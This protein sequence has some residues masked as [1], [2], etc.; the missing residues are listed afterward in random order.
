MGFF[1]NTVVKAREVLDVA[2]KRTA[3]MIEL[4]KLRVSIASVQSQLAKLFEALGRQAYDD[5]KGAAVPEAAEQELVAEI[6]AK[7]AELSELEHKLATARGQQICEACNAINAGEAA[8]CNKCG[9][10]FETAEAQ[11]EPVKV[12]PQPVDAPPPEEPEK[13]E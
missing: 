7:K 4:Q 6:D 10:K 12:T 13:P 3:E 1:E 8:F 11:A 9:A 5:M 2:G